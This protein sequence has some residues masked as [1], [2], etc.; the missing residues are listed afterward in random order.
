MDS[1]DFKERYLVFYPKLYR[2]AF[3]IV[4]CQAEAEDIVQDVY[5]QLWHDRNSL[6][7]IKNPEAYCTTVLKNAALQHL[8]H[9]HNDSIT[10]IDATDG[11]TSIID[12]TLQSAADDEIEGREALD[13]VK[14]I[15]KHL[16]PQQRDVL[17][18]R[19]ISGLSMVDIQ[20]ATGLSDGNIR[21]L[22]SRARKRIKEIYFKQNN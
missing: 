17:R 6:C 1:S 14:E 22:L 8:R 13:N 18:L 3:R 4:E 12:A 20:K 21:S 10:D 16:P 11:V 5:A 19:A 7:E 15:I 2:L 9:R